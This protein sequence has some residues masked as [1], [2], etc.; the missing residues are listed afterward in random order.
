[1]KCRL[2]SSDLIVLIPDLCTLTYFALFAKINTIVR[3][4]TSFMKSLTGKPLKYKMD[5]SIHIV[6][7]C[8]G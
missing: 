2:I 6:S 1:M 3:D 5:N 4:N 7:I 8:M